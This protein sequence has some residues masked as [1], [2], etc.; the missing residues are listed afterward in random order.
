MLP[1]G[2]DFT[3]LED[4]FSREIRNQMDYG[5][6]ILNLLEYFIRVTSDNLIKM[7]DYYALEAQ[8]QKL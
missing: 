7:T 8:T 1:E 4:L 3:D 5:L 6:L 2:F